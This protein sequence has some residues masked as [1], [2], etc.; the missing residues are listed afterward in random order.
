MALLQPSLRTLPFELIEEIIVITALLGDTRAAATL[1]QTCRSFRALVYHQFSK[2]L[3]REMFSVVFDNPFLARDVRTHG[4][5]PLPH[6]NSGKGKCLSEDIFP[7]ESEYKRRIWTES[8]IL[9]RTRP[10]QDSFSSDLPSSDAEVHTALQTLLRVISTAQPLP[11]DALACIESHPSHPPRPHPICPPLFLA[12]HVHPALILDSRNTTWLARVLA[13]GLPHALMARLTVFDG[14]GGVDVQK[15]PVEWDGFLAK[16]V[17]QI[18]L[19]TLIGTTIS[20]EKQPRTTTI[21]PLTSLASSDK[22]EGIAA[23]SDDEGMSEIDG[24]EVFG[25][26][27]TPATIALDGVRRLARIR[28]YNTAYLH[29]SRAFGPFLPVDDRSSNLSCGN[30]FFADGEE[31]QGAEAGSSSTGV[32]PV[33]LIPDS[34]FSLSPFYDPE[35]DYDDDGIS[36]PSQGSDDDGDDYTPSS[37]PSPV[38]DDQLRFDWAWIAAARQVI[39]LNLRDLLMTRHRDVLRALLSLEGLRPCSA[40]GF[41][42]AAPEWSPPAVGGSS[43]DEVGTQYREGEGWDWA[44]VE[45]QWRRCVCWLDYGDLLYLESQSQPLAQR[46]AHP[47]LYEVM[48]IIP[49]TL[50]ISHYT[51]APA[52]WPGRPTIHVVGEWHTAT[53][54]PM[55][56][57]MRGTVEMVASGDVRWTL[58]SSRED[59]DGEWASEGVQLGGRGSAIGVIG[60]WTG[61]GHEPSDPLGPFWAWKVGPATAVVAPARQHD[62]NIP[63]RIAGVSTSGGVGGGGGE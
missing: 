36:S 17:A 49:L 34:T 57:R 23:E 22:N 46:F 9:R 44:G 5:A 11:H 25:S 54:P 37:A 15:Q 62:D 13:H 14:H 7:W 58:T 55:L 16:L 18:G 31:D 1:S 39:E 41:P 38:P 63:N 29:S 24:D 48:R 12:S 50:H 6:L 20:A 19:T 52:A 26:T 28:V 42:L 32:P 56:T 10:P 4:R 21:P 59:G 60:M 51:R 8:F 43:G 47:A 33:P 45:G 53:T 27:A 30:G 61:A 40:P 3:W 2:H 35:D